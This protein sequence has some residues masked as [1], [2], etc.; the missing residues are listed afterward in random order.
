MARKPIRERTVVNVIS[1][2]EVTRMMLTDTGEMAIEVRRHLDGHYSVWYPEEGWLPCPPRCELRH[3]HSI[4]H[5]YTESFYQPKD[6]DDALAYA[7]DLAQGR[8]VKVTK[9]AKKVGKKK[10]ENDE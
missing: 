6:L 2:S 5:P 3:S 9:L 10:E 4:T 7:E 8:E 1:S